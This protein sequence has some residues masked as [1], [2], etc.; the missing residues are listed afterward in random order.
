M[1][2]YVLTPILERYGVP[3]D[4][5]AYRGA[6]SIQGLMAIIT[7]WLHRDCADPVERIISI[8]QGCV[9]P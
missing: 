3:E 4:E 2:R 6:F 7:E 9:L 1:C 5:R 8:M